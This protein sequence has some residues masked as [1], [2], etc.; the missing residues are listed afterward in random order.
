MGNGATSGGGWQQQ[1]QIQCWGS[2]A[3]ASSVER[4]WGRIAQEDV[5]E[6]GG[7]SRM[8]PIDPPRPTR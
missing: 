7:W 5:P 2:S 1:Q 8:F 6:A 3:I 4:V